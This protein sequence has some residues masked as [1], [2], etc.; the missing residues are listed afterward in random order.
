MGVIRFGMAREPGKRRAGSARHSLHSPVG[1][2]GFTMIELLISISILLVGIV[3]VAQL[4]PAAIRSNL[5]NRSDST[6]LIVVQRQLEVMAIQSMTVQQNLAIAD[7]NFIEDDGDWDNDPADGLADDF[8]IYLGRNPGGPGV[9]EAGCTLTTPA[10]APL[11]V[12]V[13]NFMA[14]PV[15]GYSRMLS[16]SSLF[17]IDPGRGVPRQYVFD[18]RW[19]VTTVATLVGGITP[20]V[21]KV[22]TVSARSIAARGFEPVASV[23]P[24]TL[25]RLVSWGR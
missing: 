11:P 7:F 24:A 17:E 22:I 10:Q 8:T 21:A 4:V 16:Y 2:S 13:C 18:V 5:R 23:P 19:H 15:P 12:G 9:T 25:R 14:A 20:V 6:A 1:Q 3:A